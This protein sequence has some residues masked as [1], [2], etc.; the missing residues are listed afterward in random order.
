MW[1]NGIMWLASK[2]ARISSHDRFI[3]YKVE[4]IYKKENHRSVRRHADLYSREFSLEAA[5][6]D[7]E[8]ASPKHRHSAFFIEERRP[9]RHEKGTLCSQHSCVRH[10][11]KKYIYIRHRCFFRRKIW[12][13]WAIYPEIQRRKS[14]RSYSRS[15]SVKIFVEKRKNKNKI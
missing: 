12:H 1:Y 3:I 10:Q 13:A 8:A 9:V 7:I 14:Q 15:K 2:V 6:I 11:N 4:W 5:G